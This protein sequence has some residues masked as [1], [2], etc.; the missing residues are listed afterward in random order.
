MG[1]LHGL[2]VNIMCG[3]VTLSYALRIGD[4]LYR[5]GERG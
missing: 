4:W 3:V 2:L 1:E 5:W